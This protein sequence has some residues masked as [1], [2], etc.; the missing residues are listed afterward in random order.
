MQEMT[1]PS[2]DGRC[3][4]CRN[5]LACGRAR[6]SGRMR[7]L[8]PRRRHRRRRSVR[9]LRSPAGKQEENQ[10]RPSAR[11]Y[12]QPETTLKDKRTHHV[13]QCWNWPSARL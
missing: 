12:T 13:R 5:R 9:F 7:R 1:G 11:M 3:R 4:R 8:V 6:L 10:I 2:S